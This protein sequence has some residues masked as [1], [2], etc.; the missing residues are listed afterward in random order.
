MHLLVAPKS[1]LPLRHTVMCG[2]LLPSLS[3]PLFVPYMSCLASLLSLTMCTCVLQLM[4]MVSPEQSADVT[5]AAYPYILNVPAC[6]WDR[7][8]RHTV[9]QTLATTLTTAACAYLIMCVACLCG[10]TCLGFGGWLAG[11]DACSVLVVCAGGAAA[12]AATPEPSPWTGIASGMLVPANRAPTQPRRDSLPSLPCVPCALAL[13]VAGVQSAHVLLGRLHPRRQGKGSG[14]GRP[15]RQEEPNG[16]PPVSQ[17]C[18]AW[19]LWAFACCAAVRTTG[20]VC[21]GGVCACS[22]I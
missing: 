8:R 7:H 18:S 14:E 21:R 17:C 5:L 12:A 3:V 6:E 20:G 19:R 11:D 9:E 16:V 1:A 2:L 13:R 15:A 10:I 4:N 22:A